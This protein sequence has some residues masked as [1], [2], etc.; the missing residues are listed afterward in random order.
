LN[1]F[2]YLLKNNLVAVESVE[3][4]FNMS[5]NRVKDISPWVRKA[6]L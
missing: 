2:S 1:V 4:I 5:T 6:A 3:S